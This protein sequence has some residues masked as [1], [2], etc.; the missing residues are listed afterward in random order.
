[1]VVPIDSDSRSRIPLFF[2]VRVQNGPPKLFDMFHKFTRRVD[3]I[4]LRMNERNKK[5][6]RQ[7]NI[8][9]EVS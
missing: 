3:F 2:E 5:C 9:G 8:N 7:I 6:V 4:L 1:M